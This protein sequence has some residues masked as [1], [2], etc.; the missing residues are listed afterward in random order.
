M[1]LTL[2]LVIGASL[3]GCSGSPQGTAASAPALQNAQ[4]N[5]L[6]A[7]LK[8]MSPDERAKYV[9]EHAD[10]VRAA[11]SQIPGSVQPKGN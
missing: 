7:K 3:V 5:D 2:L 8:A 6:A 1:K 9:Q 10:E 4:K 11:Y